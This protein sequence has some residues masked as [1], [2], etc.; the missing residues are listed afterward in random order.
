MATRAQFLP[1]EVVV[2]VLRH[3]QVKQRLTVCA[4]VSKSWRSAAAAATTS[5]DTALAGP[6]ATQLLLRYLDQHGFNLESLSLHSAHLQSLT[7]LPCSRLRS[8]QLERFK[9]QLPARNDQPGLLH[10]ATGLT[11]LCLPCGNYFDGRHD[12]AALTL[13]QKLQHLELMHS[14]PEGAPEGSQDSWSLPSAVVPGTVLAALTALSFL[15]MPV[16]ETSSMAHIS[17]CTGLQVGAAVYS[18]QRP[19]GPCDGVWPS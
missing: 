18:Q 4:L 12:L 5:I 17:S 11:R 7:R 9:L 10:D 16:A 14:L 19:V 2:L 6:Q 3:V 15:H 1:P 8:L 13:L